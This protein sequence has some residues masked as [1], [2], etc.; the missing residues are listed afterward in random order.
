MTVRVSRSL[1]AIGVV[2]FAAL[3]MGAAERPSNP[4]FPAASATRLANG[5]IVASQP[6]SQT[7]LVAA[8][9]LLPIGLQQQAPDKAGVA[10]I[11]AATILATPV[12]AGRTLTDV[13]S[14]AGAQLSYV[15][16]PADTRFYLECQGPDFPRL[17][18]D[19]RSA[20]RNPSMV[21]F[22]KQRSNQLV[23]AQNAAKSPLEAAYAMVRQVRYQ[24]TG[25]GMPDAGNAISISNLTQTDVRAFISAAQSARGTVVALSGA[26][27]PDSLAAVQ[28]EFSDFSPAAPTPVPSPRNVGR[29]H[30][31]VS[32][33]PVPSPWVAVA[34]G[35]PSR[36]SNDYAAM[37]VIQALLG[38]GGDANALAFASNT[39]ASMDYL[40][41]FYQSEAE[42]GSLII[43]LD[44]GDIDQALRDLQTGVAR[45]RA[46][47]LDAGLIEEA[48]RLAL[49]N[50]YASASGLDGSTLLLGRAAASP[51]GVDFE[52]QLPLKIAAVS[53]ADVRRI[54]GRYLTRETVAV[55]LPQTP[56]Q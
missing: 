23:T 33:R 34:Y 18:H 31:I 43:F 41:A 24:G 48:K 20:L 8:Q 54:A 12:E 11:A 42:P 40:G 50:Y 9:I 45:L 22:E 38:Q 14:D 32:H 13:V 56:G 47:S 15:V 30:E 1:A 37:L 44:G 35:A 28:R 51:V 26:T 27:G 4:S 21:A 7:P 19:L 5:V 36:Y 6:L 53:A 46:R 10:A 3:A 49:G 17:L 29:L 39:T 16:D 2:M 55:I 25:F 52:N